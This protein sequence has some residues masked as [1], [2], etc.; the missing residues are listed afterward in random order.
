MIVPVLLDTKRPIIYGKVVWENR[1]HLV[2]PVLKEKG[3]QL[4]GQQP[5]E[6]RRPMVTR[7]SVPG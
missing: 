3:G 5:D 4:R 2:F 1:I 6:I 7:Q